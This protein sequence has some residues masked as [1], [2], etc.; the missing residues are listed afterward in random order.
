[1]K[2]ETSKT[3]IEITKKT[4]S[5]DV[6]S[7][8]KLIAKPKATKK[9]EHKV[10]Y[11]KTIA[12]VKEVD[13]SYQMKKGY[14]KAVNNVSFDIHESE[15]LG[16]IGES[17]S[18]KSTI[19]RAISGITSYTSG[20]IEV[21]GVVMPHNNLNINKEQK[22][23][24]I[25]SSQYIFQDPSASLNPNKTIEKAINDVYRD[26]FKYK[27]T[28]STAWNKRFDE[29]VGEGFFEKVFSKSF[30]LYKENISDFEK[31]NK[32]LEE[33]KD[34]MRDYFI[35]QSNIYINYKT[36]VSMLS[37]RQ[38]SKELTDKEF[39]VLIRK[40]RKQKSQEKRTLLSS[41]KEE[42][43]KINIDNNQ[44]AKNKFNKVKEY[45]SKKTRL[46]KFII[47]NL[48]DHKLSVSLIESKI[49]MKLNVTGYRTK[50]VDLI[51]FMKETPNPT[52][53]FLKKQSLMKVASD[54]SL[55]SALFDKRPLTL[56]GGQQQRSVIAKALTVGA[57]LLIADEPISALDVSIQAQI[58]NTFKR[59]RSTKG[60]SI[61]FIAHD[62]N[63][64][65][66]IS[67]RI[68]IMYKG[69]IVEVGK[70]EEIFKRP[71]HPYTRM[72]LDSI[73]DVIDP[74]SKYTSDMNFKTE[75]RKWFNASST[76]KI[77]CTK[78]EF[79]KEGGK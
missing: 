32:L 40:R 44:I 47:K 58:I 16:L 4:K 39:L 77:F 24:R 25:K 41:Y 63:V 30:S 68:M 34:L 26:N 29:F 37:R 14:F 79:K 12:S 3:T 21:N 65:R 72:L 18:G 75:G 38:V 49:K 10:N 22:K 55:D 51:K 73:P 74:D 23:Y 42:T 17:G 46:L 35:Q 1:M 6:S 66:N 15:I 31:R 8:S 19:G 43:K 78:E 7:S 53:D 69:S 67:D 70:T 61:L 28:L 59:M 13:I 36:D 33:E 11:S 71:L 76:H 9:Q 56:S 2:K 48:I 50:L 54:V 57:K 5:F 62:L 60:T 52:Y 45:K 64:V 27:E 20:S